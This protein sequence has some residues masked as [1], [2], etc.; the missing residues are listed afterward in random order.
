VGAV[1]FTVTVQL[2]PPTS[3]P[4]EKVTDA[5]P[6]AGLKVGVPHPEEVLAAGVGATFIAPGEV[7]KVS[8]KATLVKVVDELGLVTVKAS[9]EIPFVPIVLGVKVLLRTAG[10]K[11][12]KVALAVFPV[13]P[14]VELTAPLRLL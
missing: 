6:A 7:G 12:D 10:A 14:L 11:V 2:P 3:V 8:E 1:I 9:V 5:F 4:P 13:P